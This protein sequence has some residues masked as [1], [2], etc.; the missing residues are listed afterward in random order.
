MPKQFNER[1]KTVSEG[2][3]YFGAYKK[4]RASE[5]GKINGQMF[6]ACQFYFGELSSL[7]SREV[8]TLQVANDRRLKVFVWRRKS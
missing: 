5:S 3:I 1:K 8:G 6:Q 4:A 7:W 2:K